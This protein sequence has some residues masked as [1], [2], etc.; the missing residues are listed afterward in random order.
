MDATQKTAQIPGG[1]V[2]KILTRG[3]IEWL[4]SKLQRTESLFPGSSK[5]CSD[6][7]PFLSLKIC[8]F[9]PTTPKEHDSWAAQSIISHHLDPLPREKLRFMGGRGAPTWWFTPLSKVSYKPCY[10]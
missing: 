5:F 2:L 10:I 8:S 9:Q 4:A 6:L 3:C 7:A 1:L